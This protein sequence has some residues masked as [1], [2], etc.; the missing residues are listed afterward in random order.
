MLMPLL[1][2]PNPAVVEDATMTS[3]VGKIKKTT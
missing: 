2:S 3:L 1:L